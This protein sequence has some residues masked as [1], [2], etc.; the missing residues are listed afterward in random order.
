MFWLNK[1]SMTQSNEAEGEKS[2]RGSSYRTILRSSSIIGG[3]QIAQ[4]LASIAKMK[5]AAV[6]LG[7]VGVGLAG[8][9]VNLIT[10]AS[11]IAGLGIGNAG[12]RQVAQENASGSI[13][14]LERTRRALRWGTL[15]QSVLSGAL[16]WSLSGWIARTFLDDSSRAA[17]VAWLS[18][19]VAL[20][21][22][23]TGQSALLTGLRRVGD[24]ARMNVSASLC[25][26]G[27]GA[28]ALWLLP[29]QGIVVMVLIAPAV[30]ALIGHLLV[31]RVPR[32]ALSDEA[33]GQPATLTELATEW[34][35]MLR[36][37]LPFM[38]SQIV[39]LLG[40]LAVRTLVQH[41]LGAAAQG[42]FQAAWG[43]GITYLGFII[44]AMATD[45]YPR[46]TEVLHD[47]PAAVRLV[48]E[49]TEVALLL[50]AP[51]LLTLLGFSP[52]I[53]PLLYSSEFGPAVE[54][55]RWQLLGDILK[56]VCFPLGFVV[57]AAGAGKTFLAVELL[58]TGVLV[59]G[60][61]VGLPLIG[62]AATGVAYLVVYV[63][64]LPVNWLLG[65]RWIG[66]RWMP[67]IKLQ[68][69]A[70]IF[71]AAIV[72]LTSRW[73][74][75]LGAVVAALFAGVAAAWALMRLSAKAGAGGILGRIGE[76]GERIKTRIARR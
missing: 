48:N 22:L 10:T 26:S 4:V 51:F 53:I 68:I 18:L 69:F 43:I 57:M 59:L 30:A 64:L 7:P 54:I 19:G 58:T 24:L 12:T 44:S 45:Y 40:Q 8:L 56:I 52:W 13:A 42:H 25:A 63:A 37:G 66:F 41:D 70:V 55:L 35:S 60:V 11:A 14:A 61:F 67:A 31:S 9:Y 62:V 39:L 23:S 1:V 32:Q 49:Q 28:L 73:S 38:V 6:L 46:L 74:V 3:S 33:S 34:R 75:L 47:R 76:V 21:V 72:Q 17:E 50:S 20:V 29:A 16:F 15:L 2:A 65:R 36:V 27:L 71:A 5:V